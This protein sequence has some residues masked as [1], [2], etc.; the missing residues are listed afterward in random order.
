MIDVS[1][2]N[3]CVIF[4]ALRSE[5]SECPTIIVV[6][7]IN[8]SSFCC[9]SCNVVVTGSSISFVMPEYWVR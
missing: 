5:L 3:G 6:G 8:L 9:T 7:V 2:R 1:M 4:R